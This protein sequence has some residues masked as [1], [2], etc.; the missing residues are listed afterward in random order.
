MGRSRRRDTLE[1][2]AASCAPSVSGL[3]KRAGCPVIVKMRAQPDVF[4][5]GLV[6]LRMEDD[7]P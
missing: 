4:V 5:L 7:C 1:A 2:C 6:V 3:T